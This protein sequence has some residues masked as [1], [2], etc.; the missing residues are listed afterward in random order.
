MSPLFFPNGATNQC[1]NYPSFSSCY[2]GCTI[3]PPYC[4]S[5]C[6]LLF[7]LLCLPPLCEF[8]LGSDACRLR[9]GARLKVHRGPLGAG[10]YGSPG[11]RQERASRAITTSLHWTWGSAASKHVK[12]KPS[13]Q[14]SGPNAWPTHASRKTPEHLK[15]M[16]LEGRPVPRTRG[17]SK[18]RNEGW[19]R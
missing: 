9:P 4:D 19:S 17:A 13:G 5:G 3:S 14:L 16:P 7:A 15:G 2:V 12:P 10:F 6:A 11:V 1:R 8:A 18:A